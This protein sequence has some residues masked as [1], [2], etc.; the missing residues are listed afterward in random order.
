MHLLNKVTRAY[1]VTN[2]LS[3]WILTSLVIFPFPL[4]FSFAIFFRH[5]MYSLVYT[6]EAAS[7]DGWIEIS[8]IETCP[9]ILLPMTW[10]NLLNGL[11][12]K[13]WIFMMCKFLALP[14][15]PWLQRAV[16]GFN[17]VRKIHSERSEFKFTGFFSAQGALGKFKNT[18]TRRM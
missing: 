9:S 11:I 15:S 12:L 4:L 14:Y 6:T 2:I 8:G 18:T 3:L 1:L 7:K 5:F 17:Q 16:V 10:Y 13:S